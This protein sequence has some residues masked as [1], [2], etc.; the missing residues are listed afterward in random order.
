VAEIAAFYR[1]MSLFQQG[2]KDD[3][4]KLATAAAAKMKPLPKDEQNPLR[5]WRDTRPP[6][7]L[8]GL[9]GSQSDD[10]VSTRPRAGYGRREI[11]AT[12]SRDSLPASGRD[13]QLMSNRT[14]VGRCGQRRTSGFR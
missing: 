1:A 3:A 10:P 4:R 13:R 11:S 2:K 8:A 14:A 7:P 12:P 6:G 5:R 9:Q